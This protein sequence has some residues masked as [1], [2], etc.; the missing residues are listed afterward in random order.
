MSELS[1][2]LSR[3]LASRSNAY[4]FSW[5]GLP[6]PKRLPHSWSNLPPDG[7]RAS[8]CSMVRKAGRIQRMVLFT[9]VFA[10]ACSIRLRR[11][12]FPGASNQPTTHLSCRSLSGSLMR[13]RTLVGLD[14]LAPKHRLTERALNRFPSQRGARLAFLRC[15]RKRKHAARRSQI[16]WRR[17]GR[18]SPLII[19]T[20]RRMMSYK[21][22]FQGWRGWLLSAVRF[23]PLPS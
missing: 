6:T 4:P 23:P 3:Q 9:L 8:C 22:S 19:S 10:S 11:L 13:W 14:S 5:V 2:L 7:A 16:E 21:L 1:S 17:C 12:V 18:S 15:P 20:R